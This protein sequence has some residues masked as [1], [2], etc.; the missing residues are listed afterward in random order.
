[1]VAF[2]MKIIS[3]NVSRPVEIIHEGKTVRTGIFKKPVEGPVYVSKLNIEGDGQADLKN[4][5]GGH[6]AVY[7]YSYDHYPYWSEVLERSDFEFGQFG[8]NLTV[9]G[10]DESILCIGDQLAVR[11]VTFSVT[12]PRVPC[13][14]LGIRF[15]D[16]DM[17]RKFMDKALT[18]CYLMVLKE[19]YIQAGDELKIISRDKNNISVK[20]LFK[21]YYHAEGLEG[22]EILK[23]ASQVTALSP[24]WRAQIKKRLDRY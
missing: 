22:D 17:P 14:K 13:S 21:A 11:E 6:K 24:S 12:Q 2:V 19:G 3:I 15:G 8:E 10:L 1:V 7:A 4:H 5:G 16:R 20:D 23:R 18:G 9:T